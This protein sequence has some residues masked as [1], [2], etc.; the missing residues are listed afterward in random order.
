MLSLLSQLLNSRLFWVGKENAFLQ[1]IALEKLLLCTWVD[2][3]INGEAPRL[4][5]TAAE[6]RV[7]LKTAESALAV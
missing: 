2:R 3:E 7:R 1:P 6:L 5:Q 4:V